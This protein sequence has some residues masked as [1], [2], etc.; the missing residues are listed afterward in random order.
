[1]LLDVLLLQISLG[2]VIEYGAG[3]PRRLFHPVIL[4]GRLVTVGEKTLQRFSRSPAS[5]IVAGGF[6]CLFLLIFSYLAVQSILQLALL[7][8]PGLYLFLGAFFIWTSLA[9]RSLIGHLEAVAR[10]LG[11]GQL[12]RSR[13]ELAK[14][15]GRDTAALPEA[16]V[17]RA[18]VETAAESLADG[19]VAPLFYAFLGGAPL[20]WAYKAANTLDSMVGYKN[21]QY[22]YFGKISARVDDAANFIPARM[23]ALFMLLAGFFLGLKARRGWQVA[24]RDSSKQPSPNSGY[25]EGA[26]AGLLDVRLGGSVSYEGERTFKPYL[27]GEGRKA[28]AGD[29][30]TMIRLIKITSVLYWAAGVLAVLMLTF[31]V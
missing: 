24:A 18:A 15:V 7:L 13:L 26:A 29:I 3:F 6:L 10:P 23:T 20:A 2:F 31:L 4:L 21:E 27:N 30:Y 5:Q 14:I 12:E 11:S 17:A 22:F 25:P 28:A 19:V 1:M 9:T 8:A 16:E